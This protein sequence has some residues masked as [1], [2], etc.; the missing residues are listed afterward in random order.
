[1]TSRG[2]IDQDRMAELVTQ[3]PDSGARDELFSMGEPLIRALAGRFSGRGESTDDLRQVASLGLLK[4]IDNYDN[5]RGDSLL[6]YATATIIGELRHHFRDSVRL[7]RIPRKLV[8]ARRHVEQCSD[9]LTQKLGRTPALREIIAASG[10]DEEIVLEAVSYIDTGRPVPIDELGE[11]AGDAA[12]TV[13][14][15]FKR[16]DEVQSVSVHLAGL[17]ERERRVLFLH[18]F[19]GYSQA[20]VAAEIGLSQ[21][22]VS[23]ILTTSL[24]QI[25]Q[26]LE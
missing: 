1:M 22:Q 14:G 19:R 13:T 18:F 4:A 12:V 23:R 9:E 16:L 7:M 17:P 8:E 5:D 6:A 3:L 15:E 24:Q 25:K 2:T 21:G 26:E 10:L 20:E 11:A